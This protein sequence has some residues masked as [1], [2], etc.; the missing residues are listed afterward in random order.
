[1][2]AVADDVFG[3]L[4]RPATTENFKHYL[5]DWKKWKLKALQ[6]MPTLGSPEIDGQPHAA[7]YDPDRQMINHADAEFQC[8]QRENCCKALK[9]IGPDEEILGDILY[10]RFIR[11]YTVTKT[12]MLIEDHYHRYMDE[13]TFM[14]WQ[15]Q[16]L[17][18]GAL[19]C[20]D[21]TVRQLSDK[22]Q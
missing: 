3:D 5:K 6:R 17:W 19:L 4:D 13:R 9:S 21:K 15:K 16:A 20:P 10:W 8:K 12:I 22:C 11:G 2:G 18:D 7:S 1:M 14:R